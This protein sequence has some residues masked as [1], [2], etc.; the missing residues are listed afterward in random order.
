MVGSEMQ[1]SAEK[2]GLQGSRMHVEVKVGSGRS[3]SVGGGQ[4]SST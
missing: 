2:G 1:G 3:N 4:V